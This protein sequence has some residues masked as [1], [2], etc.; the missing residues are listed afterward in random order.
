MSNRTIVELNH[1]FSPRANL[2][3]L[4]AWAL[5]MQLYMRSADPAMLPNGV[6]F[7]HYRHHSQDRPL[8]PQERTASTINPALMIDHIIGEMLPKAE[9]SPSKPDT[10]VE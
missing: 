2:H 7:L 1:D 9:D 3:D 6:T 4:L 10:V 8:K 5:R